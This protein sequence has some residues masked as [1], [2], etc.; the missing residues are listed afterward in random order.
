[1]ST[2]KTAAVNGSISIREAVRKDIPQM[3]EIYNE[4]ILHTTAV[5]NYDPHTLEMRTEWFETK[6]QQGF[7]VFV[8]EENNAILGFSTIGPFRAWQAYKFTVENSVYVKADCRG[9]GVGKLLMPPLINA[10]KRLGLHAIVAGIDATN[11]VSIALHKQFGFVEVAHFKEVGY[12]FDR[13]L[14]LKFLELIV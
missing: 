2:Y 12:K 4:V 8:A 1:M 14:D 13:W 11:D 7:P 9:K 10:A 6:Q 3:L 5:Y